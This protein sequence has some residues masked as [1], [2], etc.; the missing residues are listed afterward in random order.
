MVDG[1]IHQQ[2]IRPHL[3]HGERIPVDQQSHFYQG[4]VS[5]VT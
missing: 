1:G 4:G 3:G 2:K 5:A